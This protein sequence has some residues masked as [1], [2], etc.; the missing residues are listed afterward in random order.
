MCVSQISE[1]KVYV[2]RI[3]NQAWVRT[4]KK[5]VACPDCVHISLSKLHAPAFYPGLIQPGVDSHMP[6]VKVRCPDTPTFDPGLI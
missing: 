4:M 6:K 2:S 3:I 5:I 1:A